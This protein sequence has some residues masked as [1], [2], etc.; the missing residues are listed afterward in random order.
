MSET[1]SGDSDAQ[2]GSGGVRTMES[3]LGTELDPTS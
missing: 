2:Q 3:E 1:F